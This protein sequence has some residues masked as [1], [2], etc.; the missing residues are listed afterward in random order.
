MKKMESLLFDQDIL[1]EETCDSDYVF[2]SSAT[3][4]YYS[5][6]LIELGSFL[7][8]DDAQ[9]TTDYAECCSDQEEFE[10][11]ISNSYIEYHRKLQMMNLAFLPV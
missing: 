5:S 4:S 9:S 2:E 8:A 1:M 10:E 7:V 3:S 11:P 6:G